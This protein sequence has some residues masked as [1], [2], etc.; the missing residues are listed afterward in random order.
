MNSSYIT[1]IF[2]LMAALTF[3]FPLS[4]KDSATHGLIQ[5]SMNPSLESTRQSAELPRRQFTGGF[6]GYS[7]TPNQPQ[8]QT[9]TVKVTDV[10]R[11][12]R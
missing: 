3:A 7:Y 9:R 12:N 5:R 1:F 2:A 11:Y 8:T 4:T 6:S 10:P